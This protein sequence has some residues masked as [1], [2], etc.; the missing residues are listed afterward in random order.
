MSLNELAASVERRRHG[1]EYDP[2]RLHVRRISSVVVIVLSLILAA[3]RESADSDTTAPDTTQTSDG[4]APTTEASDGTTSTT[5]AET[6]GR[7]KDDAEGLAFPRVL[8]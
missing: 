3:C 1:D 5:G 4:G 6:P 8:Y 7:S 2:G